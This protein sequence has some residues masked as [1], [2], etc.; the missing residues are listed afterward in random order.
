L[1]CAPSAYTCEHQRAGDQGGRGAEAADQPGRGRG[2]DDDAAR[3]RQEREPG[4][5][6]GVSLHFLQVQGQEE[7]HWDH[8]AELQ[9]RRDVGRGDTGQPEGAQ[10]EQRPGRARLVA[11]EERQQ[12]GRVRRLAGR[13]LMVMEATAPPSDA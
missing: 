5:Q 6:G 9:Q 3:Q 10:R 13:V 8:G 2:D 1:C 12:H 7:E 4:P 11:Q